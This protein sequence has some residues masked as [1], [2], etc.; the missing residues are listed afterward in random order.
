M[1]KNILIPTDLHDG[2]PKLTHYLEA[3]KTAGARKLI[4]LHARPINEDGDKPRLREERLQQVRDLLQIDPASIPADLKAEA[5]I[6][7]RRPADAILDA[8]EKHQV[9]LVLASRPIRNLLDEKLF[10]S[11][12]IEVLQ[13]IKVPVMIMR[14]QVLWVMTTAELNLRCQ[15]LFRHLLVPYDHSPSAQHLVQQLREGVKKPDQASIASLTFCWIISD[16]G[17]GEL[18]IGEQRPKAEKIL[19][20]LKQEFT[21]YGLNVET[22]IRFGNPVVE[23]QLAAYDRDIHGIAVS[24]GSVGKIWELSIPSF[25]GEIIRRC[26]F[27]VIYF[28]PAGR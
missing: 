27:P 12:T 24:S 15:N 6:E 3:L 21:G 9:D 16:A 8:V 11:T 1:F 23:A 13:R 19:A 7:N 25:A 20:D 10:G 2:L 4:F 5:I 26:V 22:E 17:K 28:P 14:P 18:G